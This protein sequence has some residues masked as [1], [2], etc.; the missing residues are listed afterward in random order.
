MN[1]PELDSEKLDN[2]VPLPARS[3]TGDGFE[4]ASLVVRG[5]LSHFVELEGSATATGSG[6]RSLE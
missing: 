6:D 5:L 2:P 1:T 3:D 4:R